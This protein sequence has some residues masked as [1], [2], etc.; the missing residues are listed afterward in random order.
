[1]Q[2]IVTI[3]SKFQVHIPKAIREK[4]GILTHGPVTMRADAGKIVIEKKKGR[5]I[6]ALAGTFRVKNP[7]PVEHIRDYI[8]YSR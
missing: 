2:Q 5:G 6:L 8:D 4:A 7:I 1:M 3:T